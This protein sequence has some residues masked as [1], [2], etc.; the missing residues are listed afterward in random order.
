MD[1]KS[2]INNI[3]NNENENNLKENESK[4]QLNPQFMMK[5]N[6]NKMMFYEVG[7]NTYINDIIILHELSNKKF[8]VLCNYVLLIYSLINFKLL[9]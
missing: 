1:Y 5:I 2:T 3:K 9:Q 4:M 7:E 6:L 8:G